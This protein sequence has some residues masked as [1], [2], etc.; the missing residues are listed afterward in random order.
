MGVFGAALKAIGTSAINSAGSAIGGSIGAATGGLLGGIGRKK[1]ERR[2]VDLQKEL[3]ENAAELNYKYGEM[4]A[5]QAFRRQ[6]EMY[7]RTYQ[8]ESPENRVKQLEDAGLSVG[9]MY[10]G[11]Q[12]TGGMGQ[13]TTA[14][15]GSG[16]SGQAGGQAAKATEQEMANIQRQGIALQAAKVASEIDL[17]KA[18]AEEKR[19][20]AENLGETAETTRQ[21]RQ[22]FIEE[23]KQRGFSQW[24]QNIE[25]ANTYDT[26][27]RNEKESNFFENETYGTVEIKTKSLLSEKQAA[28]IAK[29]WS[30]T[31]K[32]QNA[33]RMTQA[34]T[35]LTDEKTKGYW[36]ELLNATMMAKAEETK[37]AAMK[38][39][40]EFNTGEYTNWKTWVDT[41]KGIIG[42]IGGAVK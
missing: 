37:A 22:N 25:R 12:G 21:A 9:L 4:S 27:R 31:T 16:A 26:D 3:N 5:D 40:A 13:A 18:A 41:A 11:G 1:R 7:E 2:Q 14:P 34:I 32:N 38:L 6:M 28:E 30:E 17:N 8:D 15:Q 10:G 35:N 42:A 20:G 36:Q 24:L 33:A 29:I 19:A 39:S 23:L